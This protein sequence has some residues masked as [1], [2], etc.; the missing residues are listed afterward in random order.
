LGAAGREVRIFLIAEREEFGPGPHAVAAGPSTAC[1]VPV[2][3]RFHP[4][5]VIE[6]N[7]GMH[8]FLLGRGSAVALSVHVW[9]RHGKF[10]TIQ[11]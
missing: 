5:Q 9:V 7:R 1:G 10:H 4:R 8:L 11:K 3:E 2:R 6:R